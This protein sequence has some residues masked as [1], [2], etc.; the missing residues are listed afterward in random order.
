VSKEIVVLGARNPLR[1]RL[2]GPREHHADELM[3]EA[4]GS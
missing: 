3:I 1:E 4:S 2:G